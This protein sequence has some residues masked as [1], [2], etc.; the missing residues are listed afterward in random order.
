MNSWIQPSTGT[1]AYTPFIPNKSPIRIAGFDLDYTLVRSYKSR[2]PRVA[3]D[4]KFLPNR[5]NTL[6]E[7]SK[8]GYLIVIFT[9]NKQSSTSQKLMVLNRVISILNHPQYQL[10]AFISTQDDEYRKPK[11]GMWNLMLDI[12]SDES[13]K[14]DIE[15]SFYC[16]DAAGRPGD[17][18]DS[19]KKFAENIGIRFYTPEEIFPGNTLILDSDKTNLVILMG[20][21]GSGKN[22]YYERFLKSL[23]I[24]LIDSD[25]VK[26][27]KKQLRLVENSLQNGQSVVIAAT[28]P[29]RSK[30]L[31]FIDLGEKYG[32]ETSIVYMVRNGYDWNKLRTNSVPTIVYNIY[33][34]KLE[35]PLSDEANQVVEIDRV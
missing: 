34:S 29:D 30:R 17:F 5:L 26:D 9:N 19:D 16:G 2:F 3:E 18:A 20:M 4:Y 28:N 10:W 22:T 21:P 11:I 24:N 27:K 15:N 12:L 33:Y 14:I 6:E 23:G 25:I 13:I 1:F 8:K 31:D 35:E 32:A 7:Y